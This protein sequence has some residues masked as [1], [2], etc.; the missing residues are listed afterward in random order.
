MVQQSWRSGLAAI[1][2]RLAALLFLFPSNGLAQFFQP[3]EAREVWHVGE[4]KTLQYS[5][6]MTNYTIALWQEVDIQS[7]VAS[8][9]P[10]L[11]HVTNGPDTEFK[12]Q[13]QLYN[14]NLSASNVFY[15]WLK[16][17]DADNQ[18]NMNA[19][20]IS[21][22]YFNISDTPLPV[23]TTQRSASSS[24]IPSFT[25]SSATALPATSSSA[26]TSSPLPL[27]TAAS[28]AGDAQSSAPST[29]AGGLPVGAQAGI[30]VGVS[31]IGLTCIV[32]AVLWYRHLKKQRQILAGLQQQDTI[33]QPP[34]MGGLGKI[35]ELPPSQVY[36]YPYEMDAQGH[37]AEMGTHQSFVE[38]P[39]PHPGDGRPTELGNH[40]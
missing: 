34:A 19:D 18:L 14:F 37:P 25:S 38:M 35:Q 16:E 27:S 3:G 11:V 26:T 28:G 6:T 7:G 24:G 2:L 15:M 1:L 22:P 30:G 20:A 32:C 23:T 4:S 10:V 13:G 36:Y 33:A 39:T 5:T 12:W 40:Y 17:G 31:V 8:L 29:P 9:G 21:T